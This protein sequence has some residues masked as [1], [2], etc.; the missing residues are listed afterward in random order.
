M[1]AA[2]SSST[3]VMRSV[4]HSLSSIDGK[5]IGCPGMLVFLKL[6]ARLTL[7]GMWRAKSCGAR[8][9][10]PDTLRPGLLSRFAPGVRGGGGGAL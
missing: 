3:L 2:S 5:A 6:I 8:P 1:P 4:R 10:R 7:L 9:T